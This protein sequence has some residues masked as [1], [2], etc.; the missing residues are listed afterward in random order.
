MSVA[1]A[2]AENRDRNEVWFGTIRAEVV[3][4]LLVV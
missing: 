3:E 1:W 4:G 2:P